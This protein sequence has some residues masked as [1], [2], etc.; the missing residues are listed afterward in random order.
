MGG[1]VG[2]AALI[3]VLRYIRRRRQQDEFD[4]NFDPDRVVQRD[5]TI[6]H[7]SGGTGGG[8]VVV[9][10]LK[11]VADEVVPE[12]EAECECECVVLEKLI[13]VELV[14]VVV[15]VEDA[16]DAPENLSAK[17]DFGFTFAFAFAAA[18]TG[19]LPSKAL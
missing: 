2:L 13:V 7:G 5:N 9:A 8:D 10:E 3:L 18:G 1:I 11:A 14:D 19:D 16:N 17:G 4:G 12:A 6:G 15:V